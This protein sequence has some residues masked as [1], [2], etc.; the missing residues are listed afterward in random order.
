MLPLYVQP[1]TTVTLNN[2][3]ITRG[4]SGHNGGGVFNR[5]DLTINKSTISDNVGVNDGG[6]IA[7]A[8]TLFVNDSTITGNSATGAIAFGGGIDNGSIADNSSAYRGNGTITINRSA[9]INNSAGSQG[10]AIAVDSD[11]TSMTINNSTISGNTVVSGSGRAAILNFGS[12][13]TINSSTIAENGGGTV[14][15]I[16]TLNDTFTTPDSPGVTTVQNS[17]IL[18]DGTHGLRYCPWWEHRLGGAQPCQRFVLWVHR[19]RR[20]AEYRPTPRSAGKQRRSH[21]HPRAA[22]RLTGHRRRRYDA[23]HRPARR[24]AAPGRSR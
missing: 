11:M 6:G 9:I 22:G 16:F 10:S 7:N 23:D 18:H 4:N 14:S 1:D 3:T 21:I 5:G 15:G 19:D 13:V 20:S 2:I 24:S 17:T 8:G 12:T